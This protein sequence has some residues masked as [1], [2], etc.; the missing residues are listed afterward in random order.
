MKAIYV[1]RISVERQRSIISLFIEGNSIRSIHRL[2]KA[3]PT[4]ILSLLR[5]VAIASRRYHDANVRNLSCQRVEVDEIWTYCY[6]KQKNVHRVLNPIPGIG[7]VWLWIGM[8]PDTKLAIA[9]RLGD[10]T[11]RTAGPFMKDLQSRLRNRIQLSS[12]GHEAYL[13]AVECAFGRDV[14]FAREVKMIDEKT[15]T[16]RTVVQVISGNPDPTKI[17]TSYIERLNGTVRTFC[18]RYV[19]RTNA[20]SKN[21][22]YHQYAVDLLFMAYNYCRVHGS[23]RVTP[24]MEA[25]LTDHVWE[26]GELLHLLT[27]CER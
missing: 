9:W 14:D 13:E 23:L 11:T 12:D 6:A 3:S 17:G 7:D 20:F 1:N 27:P 21:P 18:K 16:A 22:A 26:V 19:R 5:R 25:G 15:D 10:R 4:T 2:T 24:A 8:C